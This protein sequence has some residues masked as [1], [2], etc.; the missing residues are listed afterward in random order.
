ML[1]EAKTRAMHLQM[2]EEPQAEE[3][4]QPL[5]AER[6]DETILPSVHTKPGSPQRLQEEPALPTPGR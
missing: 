4:G 5:G 6:V 3:R 2:K 1:T